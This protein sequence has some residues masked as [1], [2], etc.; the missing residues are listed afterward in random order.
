[1][2]ALADVDSSISLTL[3]CDVEQATKLH[4]FEE[5]TG[6]NITVK[7]LHSAQSDKPYNLSKRAVRYLVRKVKPRFYERKE[8][9]DEI[10]NVSKDFDLA[11]FPW[12]YLMKSPKTV[13]PKVATFHDFNFKYFFGTLVYNHDQLRLLNESFIDWME[14]SFPV[15]STH[16]MENELRKFYPNVSSVNVIHLASLNMYH[17]EEMLADD[18]FSYPHLLNERY[19]LFPVHITSHK[20][21]GNVISATAIVNKKKLRFRLVITGNHTAIIKGK[22]SYLGLENAG[23]EQGD[24]LG[25]GYV[26]D[27]QMHYLQHKAFAVL[28]A[29]LYEAGNGVGLDAWPMGIPVIQSN[30]PAFEEH[31]Q[32]QGVKAFTFDPKDVSSIVKAIEECLDNDEKKISFIKDSLAASVSMTWSKTATQYLKLFTSVLQKKNN[33]H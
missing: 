18:Q 23:D 25:L 1:M 21:I 27:K 30:I 17:K 10:M 33:E 13:C 8:L 2:C 4:G 14:D 3:F 5:L 15:V 19:I 20:N 24:V 16:F 26:D 22:S 6:R 31:L 9:E 11:Y 12:P 7:Q 29:S 28:N 32:L